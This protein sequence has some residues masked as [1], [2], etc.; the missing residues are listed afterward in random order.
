M[1]A[2]AFGADR[3]A[4][5]AAGMNDHIG[6]P[7]NPA[8]LYEKMLRW[9]DESRRE[10]RARPAAGPRRRPRRRRRRPPTCWR[11]STAWTSSAA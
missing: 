8:L 7:V 11:T 5:L 6:K 4:C 3:D 2:S 1:T 9:L 10:P